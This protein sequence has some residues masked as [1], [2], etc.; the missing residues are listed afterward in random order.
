MW[1][2]VEMLRKGVTIGLGDG[3]LEGSD[4]GEEVLRCMTN[5]LSG[6]YY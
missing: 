1:F 6:L 4:K 2:V 5:C 3:I